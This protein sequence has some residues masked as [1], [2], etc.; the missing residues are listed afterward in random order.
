L[1][2]S[3]HLCGLRGKLAGAWPRGAGL[4]DLASGGR[5]MTHTI[6]TVTLRVANRDGT[7]P[8]AVTVPLTEGMDREAALAAIERAL[9]AAMA[10]ADWEVEASPF[11]PLKED[12][13]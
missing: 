13:A 7:H 11:R 8:I 9:A 6:R 12:L 10:E 4:C 5:G 2:V 1:W 3:R